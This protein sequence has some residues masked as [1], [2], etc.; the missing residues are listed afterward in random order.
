MFR[1]KEQPSVSV[2]ALREASRD[3]ATGQKDNCDDARK[4]GISINQR[5]KV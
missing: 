2:A 3:A 4:I 1:C 5:R